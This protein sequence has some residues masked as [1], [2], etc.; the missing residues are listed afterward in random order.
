MSK[1]KSAAQCPFLSYYLF[2]SEPKVLVL[3][4]GMVCDGT[5][6]TE[7]HSSHQLHA[8]ANGVVLRKYGEFSDFSG[9]F[10]TVF[11]ITV[12]LCTR[13]PFTVHAEFVFISVPDP[14]PVD[15]L[16]IT[17]WIRIQLDPWIRIQESP[18]RPLKKVLHGGLRRNAKNRIE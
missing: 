12:H 13:I 15:T 14:D 6:R 9:H 7:L 17:P 10:H 2:G 1:A 3:K 4:M 18:S 11:V 5:S 16:L 8:A